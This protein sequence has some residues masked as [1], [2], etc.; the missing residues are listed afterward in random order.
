MCHLIYVRY[1]R[2]LKPH[3]LAKPHAHSAGPTSRGP[4]SPHGLPP[5]QTATERPGAPSKESPLSDPDRGGFPEWSAGPAPDWTGTALVGAPHPSDRP[6]CPCPH[7][8]CTCTRERESPETLPNHSFPRGYKTSTPR[9][10]SPPSYQTH[11]ASSFL[12]T[13]ASSL[14][15]KPAGKSS[16]AV[17]TSL[18]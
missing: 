3:R 14:A 16:M 11:R 7:L 1:G 18:L 8:P 9:G 15:Q 17:A 4:V 6:G 2:G 10:L 12:V 5:D 13:S